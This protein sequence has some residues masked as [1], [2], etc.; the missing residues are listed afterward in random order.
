MQQSTLFLNAEKPQLADGNTNTSSIVISLAGHL[1]L[2]SLHDLSRACRQFRA[3]LLQCRKQLIAQSLRCSKED[4]DRSSTH[5]D[6]LREAR[7]AWRANGR[8]DYAGRMTSGKVGKCARDMVGECR[9]CGT[10]VCRVG[11]KHSDAICMANRRQELHRKA[12]NS[13]GRSFERP[14]PPNLSYVHQSP[15]V[16]SLVSANR[17]LQR[18]KYYVFAH[19]LCLIFARQTASISHSYS[20]NN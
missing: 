19:I 6:Q 5:A 7:L 1:D 14:P 9:N 18:S 8:S 17:V 4:G 20:R 10:V 3:N 2:N 16:T 11:H 12:S 15:S 13:H